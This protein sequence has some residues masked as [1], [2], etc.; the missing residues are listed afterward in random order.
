MVTVYWVV[1]SGLAYEV[2]EL[3]LVTDAAGDHEKVAD[4]LHEADRRAL[5]PAVM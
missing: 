5:S 1:T 4:V 3:G 2:A